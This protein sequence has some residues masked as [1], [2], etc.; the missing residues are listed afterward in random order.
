MRAPLTA[1]IS[2]HPRM[3]ASEH[4]F[5]RAFG[6]DLA[7]GERRDA[8]ADIV[9]AVEIVRH[10]EDGKPQ[11]LL[12][13]PDQGI[14][15]AGG[16]RIEARGRLVEKDNFR[17]ESQ[18]ASERDALHHAARE[19]GGK[20]GGVV[21]GHPD[22]FELRYRHFIHEPLRKMQIFAH[23]KLQILEHGQGRKQRALLKQ[24]APA[25]LDRLNIFD[26]RLV[27][28]DAHNFDLSLLLGQ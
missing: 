18:R 24:Y 8:V 10:H 22:H 26:R 12:Q 14:E 13:G 20:F 15:I 28:I 2:L 16:D 9:Q 1:E 19:F 6:D 7:V 17:I 23:R 4:R 21:C 11:G 5:D 3:F 25:P 27:D